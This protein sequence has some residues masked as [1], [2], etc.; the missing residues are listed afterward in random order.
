MI[1]VNKMS[2]VNRLWEGRWQGGKMQHTMITTLAVMKTEQEGWS[3]FTLAVF[4]PP[5]MLC[6]HNVW[7]TENNVR[8]NFRHN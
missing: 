3:S 4:Y 7:P 1:E 2:C 6:G 5:D 8:M